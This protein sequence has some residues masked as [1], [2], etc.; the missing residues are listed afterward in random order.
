MFRDRDQAGR[1]LAGRLRGRGWNDPL[2]LAIPRGGVAVGAALARGLSAEL[3]VVLA[4]KLQAPG[5]PE[6]ALGAVAE[7]GV[8]YL[9]PRAEELLRVEPAY[10]AVERE[11]QWREIARRS[12][13]FR[14][15]R[16]RAP[17]AGRV[18]I[19]TD[20]GLATGSTMKAALQAV[21]AQRPAEL[22]LAVP[23]AAPEGFR[24]AAHW[25][26]EAICLL[27]PADFGSVGQFYQDFIPVEDGQVVETL[28]AFA[29]AAPG[30][31]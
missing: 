27:L 18:V 9:D 16:P 5:W 14:A 11:H 22:V 4:R 28:R 15:V 29:P 10:L 3:D 24:D 25:A 23:V 31:R 1:L 12:R 20:D 21:H 13:L 17:V 2:V 8:M 6:L 30:V 26:D 7:G 19:V